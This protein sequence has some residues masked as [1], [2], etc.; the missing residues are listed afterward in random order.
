MFHFL[1]S[2]HFLL[3]LLIFIF[4]APCYAWQP[5]TAS[6][7]DPSARRGVVG[8]YD[9]GS[10]RLIFQGGESTPVSR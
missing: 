7:S 9:A 1:L 8:I 2:R 3:W 10:N 4:E 5:L 6:G